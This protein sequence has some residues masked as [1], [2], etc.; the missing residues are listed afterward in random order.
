MRDLSELNI[1]VGGEPVTR[2]AP[3]DEAIAKFERAFGV[4]L[5][6][7]YVALLRQANGGHPELDSFQLDERA[8]WAVNHFYHLDDDRSSSTSLWVVAERWRGILGKG[9]LPFASDGGGNQFVLDLRVTPAAVRVCI[10]D[11][12]FRMVALA[13]SFADFIDRLAIDPDMI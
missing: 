11:E 3:S 1:N 13:S 12:N 5:P 6:S 8:T 9:V 10:H 7:E 2:L 4:V